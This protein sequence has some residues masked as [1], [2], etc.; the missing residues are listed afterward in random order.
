MVIRHQ[1]PFLFEEEAN[2]LSGDLFWKPLLYVTF[3]VGKWDRMKF[4]ALGSENM[5]VYFSFAYRDGF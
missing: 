2:P 5:D 3:L 1:N 4:R